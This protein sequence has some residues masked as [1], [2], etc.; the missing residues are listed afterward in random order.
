MR[1]RP[2][3]PSSGELDTPFPGNG[4]MAENTNGGNS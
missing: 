4:H 3:S 2:D 1:G